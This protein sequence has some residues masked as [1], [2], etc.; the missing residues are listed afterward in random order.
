MASRQCEFCFN[1]ILTCKGAYAKHICSCSSQQQTTQDNSKNNWSKALNPLVSNFCTKTQLSDEEFNTN[2]IGDSFLEDD[3]N[4]NESSY[5][6][7]IDIN[8]IT[9][10]GS[11]I[12]SSD[13]S[14]SQN[15]WSRRNPANICFEIMLFQLIMTHHASLAM[16]DNICQVVDEYTSSPDFSVLSK[17]SR[18]K[19]IHSKQ[20]HSGQSK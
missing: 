11:I 17:L 10:D 3:F 4:T 2:G 8:S 20:R 1:R 5:A 19:Y 14:G 9:T 7:K 12:A 6:K 15:S 16:F 13:H 18:R